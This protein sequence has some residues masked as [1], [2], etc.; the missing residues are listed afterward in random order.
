MIK[1]YSNERCQPCKATKRMMDNLGIDYN[2]ILINETN[3]EKVLSYGFKEA[4][5]VVLNDSVSWSG[6]QPDRINGLFLKSAKN[7]FKM[8]R[9]EIMETYGKMKCEVSFTTDI[10]EGFLNLEWRDGG[11]HCKLTLWVEDGGVEFCFYDSDGKLRKI[12]FKN[13]GD[14]K[15][16]YKKL[17]EL[18][19]PREFK[20]KLQHRF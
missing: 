3:R 19:N 8:I 17:L 10:D 16:N 13:L 18:K 1:I 14:L 15:S 9:S 20:V 2:D 4:P 7:I 6:F 5:V 11:K 12:Y